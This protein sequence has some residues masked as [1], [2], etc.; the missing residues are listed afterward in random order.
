[1][2]EPPHQNVKQ[3]FRQGR[4][5][6]LLIVGI[7]IAVLLTSTAL[8]FS[9]NRGGV[10]IVGVL[11]TANN[12]T[13]VQPPR[14]IDSAVLYDVDDA[15]S[16]IAQLDPLWTIVIPHDG[17]NCDAACERLLYLTRQIHVAIGRDVNRI[18]RLFVSASGLPDIRLMINTLSDGKTPPD[19]FAGLLSQEHPGLELRR[20]GLA[21]AG[22]LF[23]EHF[24]EPSTFY[25]VDPAGWIMMS[26]NSTHSYKA[27]IADLKFLLKNSGG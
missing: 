13:L 23:A 9:V 25:L 16:P 17:G 8:W 19:D 20:V 26:Y 4:R 7:P 11:G 15:P 22:S 18:R 12:G 21:A 10:D 1:M 5:T 27:V 6:L 2:N 24:V 3:D 14:E